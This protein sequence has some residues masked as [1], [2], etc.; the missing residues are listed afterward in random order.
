MDVVYFN[1]PVQ[2]A[3]FS[4]AERPGKA[5]GIRMAEALNR[6]LGLAPVPH[7]WNTVTLAGDVRHRCAADR[8]TVGRE[9]REARAL[10]A[11]YAPDPV[12]ASGLFTDTTPAVASLALEMIHSLL[13]EGTVTVRE[14]P[15]RLCVRCGHM[16]GTTAADGC[17]SCGNGVTRGAR[18][19]LL[20]FDRAEDKPVLERADF[21]AA[22]ARTP[23]HL[24]NMAHNVPRQLVLSRTRD[25]GV[26]L[27]PLGLE[28]LVL[29]PRA[30]LHIAVLA[31]AAGHGAVQPVM[32]VTESAA[33]NVAAY[34]APFRRYGT[35]R[36]RYALH[37]RVPYGAAN[38]RLYEVHR[39][40]AVRE[41]FTDWYLPLCAARE[42][43]G[44]S[45]ARLPALLK[46]LRRVDLTRPDRPQAEVLAD[47]RHRAAAGDM[48]WVMDARA[49]ACALA[50]R[51]NAT[52]LAG[53][54]GG[55]RS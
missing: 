26:C 24:L 36:L 39:A 14:L 31:A 28:G 29:D 6:L 50:D 3:D 37:G 20:V 47:V 5:V 27:S 55:A 2:N 30:G 22:G 45:A 4:F 21:H 8:D 44:V 40:E 33:A 43:S 46:F 11:K 34:G 35:T 42:R 41:L 52:G 23:V 54:K 10:A 9:Q 38:A 51:E 16:T 12:P 1:G 49:L 13:A 17:R 48:S 19:A 15:V 7:L 18:R 25:H 53:S 32:T